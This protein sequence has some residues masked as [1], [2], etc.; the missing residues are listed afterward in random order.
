MSLSRPVVISTNPISGYIKWKGSKGQWEGYF[1]SSKE[2]DSLGSN[3]KFVVLDQLNSVG[4]FQGLNKPEYSS[5]EVKD[6]QREKFIVWSKQ[7]GETKILHEGLYSDIQTDTKAKGIKFRKVIYGMSL[8]KAD[9]IVEGDIIKIELE[10]SSMK[11]W[12]ELSVKDGDVIEVVDT[13]HITGAITYYEPVYKKESLSA[14]ATELARQADEEL[15][16]YLDS[17]KKNEIQ[18]SESKEEEIPF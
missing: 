11:P 2:R 18:E 3:I 9:E 17:F 1:P 4:L 13:K 5:N 16:E 8:F 6:L 14:E 7:N 10:G 15:Q 12:F